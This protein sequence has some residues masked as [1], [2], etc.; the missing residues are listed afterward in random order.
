MLE[1]KFYMHFAQVFLSSIW[2]FIP[3]LSLIWWGLIILK[4]IWFCLIILFVSWILVFVAIL[5]SH[6]FERFS[7][8][9]FSVHKSLVPTSQISFKMTTFF[10]GIESVNLIY[11]WD[12][13]LFLGLQCSWITN[14]LTLHWENVIYYWYGLN[15]IC[16][17]SIIWGIRTH[18]SLK[19]YLYS[20]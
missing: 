1:L 20:I 11:L 7:V 16:I 9:I 15:F 14:F 6:G 19:F 18:F 4:Q 10:G 5:V 3:I 13:L 12:D 17:T 8:V 2:I